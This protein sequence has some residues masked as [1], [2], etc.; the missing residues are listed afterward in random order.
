MFKSLRFKVI[1]FVLT[2]FFSLF[3]VSFYY[4]EQFINRIESDLAI[5]IISQQAST[6]KERTESF[7]SQDIQLVKRSLANQNIPNWLKKDSD[8][9]LKNAALKDL[10]IDC[11]LLDCYGWFLIAHRTLRNIDWAKSAPTI[12]DTTLNLDVNPWYTKM[13]N[14]D[15][16]VY[17]DS[18]IFQHDQNPYVFFDFV[19]REAGEPLG[20][21]GTFIPVDQITTA[22]LSQAS[23]GVVNFLIDNRGY[24]HA[25]TERYVGKQREL[26]NSMAGKQ[27]NDFLKD[28]TKFEEA[29]SSKMLSDIDYFDIEIAG[30]MYL[31]ARME[32]PTLNWSVISLFEKSDIA[33]RIDVFPL[34]MVGALLLFFLLGLTI[35][36]LH[37]KIF[38][39]L[40]VIN[41]KV[42]K[43][44]AGRHSEKLPIRFNDELDQVCISINKMSQDIERQVAEIEAQNRALNEAIEQAKVA[45]NAKSMF[46]ANMSH[47]LRT[48]MNAVLGFASIGL[49]SMGVKEKDDYLERIRQAGHHLLQI[50]NDI[51]DFSKIESNQLTLELHPFELAKAIEKIQQLN[52]LIAEQKGIELVIQM[53]DT[54]PL[55]VGDR[56][57]LEQVLLNLV[58]NAVKFTERGAVTL[59]IEVTQN[60]EMDVS[61]TFA[62]SDTGIGMTEKQL[63]QLFKAFFQ[64]DSSTTRKYGGTGLGLAISKQLVDAMGGR[65][66]VESTFGQGTTF[67]FTV[68]MPISSESERDI[69]SSSDNLE[70]ELIS[71]LSSKQS[72]L[73]EDNKVNQLIASKMLQTLGLSVMVA[74]NG[75]EAIELIKIHQFDFV[76]MD[77]QMPVMDGLT[78]T[79]AIRDMA[80][81]I[82]IIGMSAHATQEDKT[83]AI[84]AGM[85]Q[86]IIKP[87]E[88]EKL[89]EALWKIIKKNTS[90]Q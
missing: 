7:F 27:W 70:S 36:F 81:E 52:Q 68:T 55:V 11:E 42:E 71:H 20:V 2:V 88:K 18:S 73:V 43:I 14:G 79:T 39:R 46:L 41:D 33:S 31:A 45:N 40:I 89:V 9:S 4:L 90:I 84:E 6:T 57:R 22:V 83:L 3:A 86:Y 53:P 67:Y 50:I 60:S 30:A 58:S 25:Q 19:V 65:I 74:E 62:V 47:E 59:K 37:N 72:L 12:R 63:G 64:A 5:Q 69:D 82:P 13:I 24:V 77:V 10:R 78:A 21:V 32:I 87:I 34:F 17:I 66:E 85:D 61:L 51:L 15:K 38:S 80:I 76:F 23:N 8:E 56:L 44:S 26:I 28:K 75:K 48:P 54:L 1:L 29:Y 49:D 16:E 35:Y